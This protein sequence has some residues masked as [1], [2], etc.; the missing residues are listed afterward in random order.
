MPDGP[1]TDRAQR[2]RAVETG[3]SE[4]AVDTLSRR[5]NPGSD[6]SKPTSRKRQTRAKQS[7]ADELDVDRK[8]VGSVDR[9]GGLDVFLRSEGVD[10]FGSDVANDFASEADFVTSEDVNPR[11]DSDDISANPVVAAGRRDDVA[12]RART[13]TAADAE[14]IQA[15]DL[16]ADVGKRGVSGLAVA[17]NRRD[18]VAQ[19]AAADIAS[20]DQFATPADISV[21]VG[22]SGIESAGF[23][24]AG[25]RRRAGRQLESQTALETVDPTADLT[26]SGDGLA[27]DRAAKRRATARSFEDDLG[28]FGQGS[29]DPSD[30]IRPTDNGF[31]L[32][33][34]PA[35]RVAA[36]QIDEQVGEV[37]VTPEM[38]ELTQTDSGA[39]EA[40]FETEVRR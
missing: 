22:P 1:T 18:D 3:A 29:L 17:P 38:V 10:Q 6:G 13:Q 35:R 15:G 16:S 34:E 2:Q 4:T 27:L 39:F 14:F 23:T 21:D 9:L 19:R 26:D 40:S 12:Q 5:S 37:D 8:G 11:V 7:V 24:D 32:A 31:G 36:E 25:Q 33:R 30:D 28:L 20:D